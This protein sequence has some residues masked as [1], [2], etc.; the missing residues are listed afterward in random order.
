VNIEDQN[1][2]TIHARLLAS[3]DDKLDKRQGSVVYDMTAP[4]AVEL[5]LAYAFMSTL[6]DRGFADT[7][8]GTDLDRRVA[9]QGLTRR[10]SV[11][12]HGSVVVSGTDG[13][14]VSAG[15]RVNTT[16]GVQFTTDADATISVGSVT[17]P[18]TAVLG[19]A[20]G[21]VNAN[22]ITIIDSVLSGVT[23][24]TNPD[25]TSGGIDEESDAELLSRYLEKVSLPATS[26]NTY[27]YKQTAKEVPGVQD[28]R[29][30]PLWNG[31]GTVKVVIT[32]ND[33]LTASAALVSAVVEHVE[34]M[35]PIGATVTVTAATVRNITVSA[36]L[37]LDPAYLADEVKAEITA[38]IYEYIGSLGLDAGAVLYSQIMRVIMTT[39]GVLNCSA[40]T[41][42]G[43][44][45][46]VTLAS[47][48]A[49]VVAGVTLIA[50]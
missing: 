49:P 9:E 10:P 11:T 45:A 43:S 35:R 44:A 19:G 21:N 20:A 30:F 29:V 33:G 25:V 40:L 6:L 28:A 42:N 4:T 2:D 47:D 39:D 18:V 34:D 37:Q 7:A 17:V 1:F 46:D 24:V 38:N 32:S 16:H 8:S 13:F 14:V 27:H 31:A 23:G 5:E 15:T 41:L 22:T 26:G 48:D 12:A 3:V 50:D 36:H